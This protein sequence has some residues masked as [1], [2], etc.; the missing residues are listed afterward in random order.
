MATM[1]RRAPEERTPPDVPCKSL[2]PF[3]HPRRLSE[4]APSGARRCSRMRARTWAVAS[5]TSLP[6]SCPTWPCRSGCTGCST[7]PTCSSSW[8][9]SRRRASCC[10]PTSSSTTARTGRSCPPRRRTCGWASRWGSWCGRRSTAG[11]TRTRSTTR[12]RATSTV[13]A[14]AT[15]PRWTVAEYYSAGFWGRLG[16]R[17]FRNPLVMFGIG[18]L[19]A[20]VIQPRLVSLSARPRLRNSVLHDQPRPGRARRPA[21]LLDRARRVHPHLAAAGD[22]GRRRRSVALLRAAPVRGRLLGELGRLDAT[23]T[24]R[25]AAART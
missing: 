6:R 23:P 16:Y 21:D 8:W 4:S 10:A 11:A 18:P 19:W 14:K 24:P 22:A 15:S 12:P 20:L 7:C 2:P 13:A 17:L 9:R 3:H 1:P 25:C 5:P